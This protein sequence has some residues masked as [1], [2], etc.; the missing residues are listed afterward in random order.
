MR[1]NVSTKFSL[2]LGTCFGRG[3]EKR[4]E[5]MALCL[6]IKEWLRTEYAADIRL[7]RS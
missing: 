1:R 4:E 2:V 5:G 6:C 3:G 7:L